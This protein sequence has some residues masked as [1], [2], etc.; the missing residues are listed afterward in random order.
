MRF[1]H[2]ADLHIDAPGTGLPGAAAVRRAQTEVLR[3][4]IGYA[5]EQGIKYIVIAGDLLDHTHPDVTVRATLNALFGNARDITF[6]LTAGNHDPLSE[7]GEYCMPLP[8]NV[9]V[10][11]PRVTVYPTEDGAFVGAGLC[12]GM[13]V[14]PFAPADFEGV[15][16]GIFHGSFND[17]TPEYAISPSEVRESGYDYL[18]LGH[19]HKPTELSREG[20]THWQLCGSPSAH[21]FD[22]TGKRSF[23]DVSVTAEGVNTERVYTECPEFYEENIELGADDGIE[24]LMEGL[25]TAATAH[26]AQDYVRVRLTGQTALPIPKELPEY[27]N[28]VEI[29]DRTTLPDDTVEL[30]NDYSLRGIFVTRMRT[31]IDEAAPEEKE[32]YIAALRVGLEAFR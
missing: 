25:V 1:V 13:T 19:I 5:E 21:G 22:E 10:F 26:R 15:K 12:E 28:L 14:H 32:K 27:P 17:S 6:L 9:V 8:E 18:A 29:I 16:V 23:L 11:P 4:A 31:L 2:T 30:E 7:T 3:Q 24:H 20:Y